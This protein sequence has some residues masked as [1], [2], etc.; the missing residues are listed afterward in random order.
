MSNLFSYCD[1]TDNLQSLSDVLSPKFKSH[2]QDNLFFFPP[3]KNLLVKPDE[4]KKLYHLINNEELDGSVLFIDSEAQR[5][6]PNRILC[7]YFNNKIN[8]P[9]LN[10]EYIENYQLDFQ[11]TALTLPEQ[12]ELNASFKNL[13]NSINPDPTQ[14]SIFFSKAFNTDFSYIQNGNEK[15][16]EFFNANKKEVAHFFANGGLKEF[17]AIIN[18]LGDGCAK[19]IGSEFTS[20]LYGALLKENSSDSLLFQFFNQDV[21][22]S[23]LNKHGGDVIGNE[24]NPFQNPIVR[25]YYLS[26]G[27][28]IK[29]MA[30]SIFYD[31]EANK[32]KTSSWDVIGKILDNNLKSKIGEV[33]KFDDKEASYIAAYLVLSNI[34]NSDVREKLLNSLIGYKAGEIIKDAT[35]KVIE[36]KANEEEAEEEIIEKSPVGKDFQSKKRCRSKEKEPS[37]STK[38]QSSSKLDYESESE[39]SNDISF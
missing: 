20:A 17:S 32:I 36:E 6:I 24:N 28:L 19:N 9:E 10:T 18:S 3:E 23:I 26:P 14:I 11:D 1:I 35:K 37:S 34:E 13:L 2:L 12:N 25:G 22:A 38:T 39:K 30:S 7:N 15:L 4:I 29:Q 8:V 27:A 16:A 21:I 33:I 5:F 31:E